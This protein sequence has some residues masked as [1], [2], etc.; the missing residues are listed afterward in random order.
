MWGGSYY[1]PAPQA[2]DIP[3]QEY[4]QPTQTAPPI[5]NLRPDIS[6][7]NLT[8]VSDYKSELQAILDQKLKDGDITKRQHDAELERLRQ[9]DKQAKDDASVNRGYLTGDQEGALVR[10]YDRAYYVINHNFVVDQ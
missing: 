9:L 2:Y 10:Q 8:V 6:R 4:A 1:Y 3:P 7:H 5:Q